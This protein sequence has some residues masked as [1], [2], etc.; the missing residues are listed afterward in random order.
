MVAESNGCIEFYVRRTLVATITKIWDSTSNSKIQYGLLAHDWTDTVFD[1]TYLILLYIV[2][3]VF[4][5]VMLEFVHI[6]KHGMSVFLA[7]IDL[8]VRMWMSG[9]G[10]LHEGAMHWK[11]ISAALALTTLA[12][13]RLQT[14]QT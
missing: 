4:T 7:L 2:V 11:E 14:R 3:A 9:R 8:R 10:G 13:S 1:R 12:N 6:A 5:R